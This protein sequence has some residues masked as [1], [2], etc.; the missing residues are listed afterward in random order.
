MDWQNPPY[1]HTGRWLKNCDSIMDPG[2]KIT[3]PQLIAEFVVFLRT[4]V[5]DQYK[6]IQKGKEWYRPIQKEVRLLNQQAAIICSYFPHPQD[7]PLVT[8]AVKKFFR[9]HKPLGIGGFRKNRVSKKAGRE[10]STVTQTEKDVVLGINAELMKAL[11]TR[12]SYNTAAVPKEA[13]MPD[14]VTFDT[15]SATA[16]RKGSLGYLLALEKEMKSRPAESD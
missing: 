7:E 4:R 6:G 11:K 12:E 14:K 16:P 5:F 1:D 15:G 3:W 13:R 8:Y 10:H 9:E 2:S